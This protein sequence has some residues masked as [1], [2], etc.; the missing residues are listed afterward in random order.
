MS[1]AVVFD[2]GHVARVFVIFDNNSH[3]ERRAAL[4]SALL[5]RKWVGGEVSHL[6]G[7]D[8]AHG[9]LEL[10]ARPVSRWRVVLNPARVG[11]AGD[12]REGFV[13]GEHCG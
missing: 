9:F 3:G 8:G 2:G 6:L 4:V 5:A 13:D 10:P 7:S 1:L 11:R 12:A